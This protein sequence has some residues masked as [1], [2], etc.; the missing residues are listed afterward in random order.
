MGRLEGDPGVEFHIHF[1]VFFLITGLLPLT[2]SVTL[3]AWFVSTEL[4]YLIIFLCSHHSQF[5]F[6]ATANS[7]DFAYLGYFDEAFNKS[8]DLSHSSNKIAP[9]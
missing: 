5:S 9:G 8:S 4:L 7:V 1:K 2:P 6:F 3:V